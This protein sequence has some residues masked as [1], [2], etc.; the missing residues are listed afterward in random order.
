MKLL[1]QIFRNT[2]STTE[3]GDKQ[4]SASTR[5][6]PIA[7]PRRQG[8]RDIFRDVIGCIFIVITSIIVYLTDANV[9]KFVDPILAIISA[10]V[11][12]YLSYPHRKFIL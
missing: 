2:T 12:F 7:M 5:R 10:F 8:F 9:A 6:S 11:L 3:A 4:L 1:F